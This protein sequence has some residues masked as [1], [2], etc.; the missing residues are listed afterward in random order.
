M[1]TGNYP[2]LRHQQRQASK[3]K[4]YLFS[5]VIGNNW[6]RRTSVYQH[7]DKQAGGNDVNIH[8]VLTREDCHHKS[9][10]E[11]NIFA[12]QVTQEIECIEKHQ[13]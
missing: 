2:N 7:V 4:S 5:S 1:I 13:N 10:Q 9:G 6:K 11:R 8:L 3:T 12:E